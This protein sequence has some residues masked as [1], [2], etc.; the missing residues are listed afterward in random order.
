MKSIAGAEEIMTTFFHCDTGKYI[1]RRKYLLWIA[2][3]PL[4]QASLITALIVIVNFRVF[5]ERGYHLIAFY[6]VSA[7]A[8]LGTLIFFVTYFLTERAVKRNARYTFFEIGAKALI[9][10]RYAG[11]YISRGK[12][13]IH[14]KLYIIPLSS[15][16]KIGYSEKK[17]SVYLE[18]GNIRKYNDSTEHLKY[19]LSSGFPEFESW[20]YNEHGFKTSAAVKI[21]GLFGSAEKLT[22]VIAEAKRAFEE[23]PKPKPYVH[24]ESDYVKKKMALE[25]I[26]RQI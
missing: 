8:A 9:Y 20:W 14:R 15:L 10:S 26:K 3:L 17:N 7:A 2:L 19:R 6:A 25:R 24:K 11:D 21:P 22:A 23:Q 13:E 1:K 12:L 5:Y 4:F 16:K 18:A